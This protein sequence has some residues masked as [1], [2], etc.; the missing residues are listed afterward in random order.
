M[1]PATSDELGKVVAADAAHQRAGAGADSARGKHLPVDQR[2]GVFDAGHAVDALGD[3][4]HSR[5]AACRSAARSDG[6]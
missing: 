2:D 5:R 6:R 1:L 4:R 3:R